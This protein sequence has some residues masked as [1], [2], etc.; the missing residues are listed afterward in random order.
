MPVDR[1][2]PT[3]EAEDLLALTRE[4]ADAELA[5][6]AAV[7]ER[8]ERF[9]REVFRL[10]GEAGLMGLPFPEEVGGGGQPYAV[11]L[12]VLEELAAR[13]ATVALGISVHTLACS[14][15]ANFGTEAQRRDLLPEMVGGTLLGAYSLSEAHAGSDVAAMRASAT[16]AD[17][18]WVARGEKAWVTHGG[19][20]DFY[21]TFLRTPADGERAISCFHLTPDL[22]GFG[23][24]RPEEKM[25]LTGS[26][27]A[28][29]RLDDVPVP[30]DR[31]V[32]EPGRGMA[33]ALG[34]LDSGRLGI[35]A[36]AV[37]LAQSALDV[38]VA[39]AVEREAFGRPIAEHQG[40]QFLLADMAAAVE[41]ARATYLVAARRKDA[42][43]PFSRQASIAKLVA[44]DAAMKVTTDAVQVLGGAGYTRDHP[45][46]RYMREA[47][48]MQIFEGT[49]QIQRMVIGRHLT[50]GAAPPAG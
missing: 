45:A 25:G 10:L 5:P 22:P 18:G 32:G 44:T 26:T 49:N 47:K 40:V 30:A 17:G 35:S 8:E 31:L 4:I 48:V 1:E 28:A 9:P 23:A 27:T 38:A 36:V 11:Y 37:G 7:H 3:P 2:L 14:P 15:I 19:H 21:S 6:K 12:Q 29:I 41:S 39:Y 43:K 50:A 34:A 46:E 20:A 24:A 16:P 33:I 13:W 42:G